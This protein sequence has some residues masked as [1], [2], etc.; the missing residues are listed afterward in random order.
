M[1]KAVFFDLYG[2]LARFFPLRE[3]VQAKACESFGL[4]VTRE[5][6]V[7]GYLLADHWMS[8]VNAGIVPVPQLAEEERTHFFTEYE[9]LVL[10]GAGLEADSETARRV[11]AKVRETPY[12]LALFDDALP[13]LDVL[14][15]RELTLGLLSNIGRD[16]KALGEELGLAPYLD[17]MITSQ[18]AGSSK[19]HPPIFLMALERAGVE[20]AEALHVGDSHLSDVQGARDV[21]INPLLLDR[22]GVMGDFDDCP[23]IENLVGVLDYIRVDP[24]EE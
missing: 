19:P 5:G 13:V 3:E 20:P 24:P 14:K 17:F 18:E 22:E 4:A 12:D 23:R 1:I 2:T 16:I 11:W 7:R 9:R 21:G 8:R 6:L 10:Q 15:R